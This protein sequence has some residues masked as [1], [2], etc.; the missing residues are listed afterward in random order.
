[1]WQVEPPITS[2][3]QYVEPTLWY[4]RPPIMQPISPPVMS[5]HSSIVCYTLNSTASNIYA[6][7]IF[8]ISLRAICI[9]NFHNCSSTIKCQ[10]FGTLHYV[11]HIFEILLTFHVISTT[12]RY[13]MLLAYHKYQIQT[14]HKIPHLHI[15][16]IHYPVS[17]YS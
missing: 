9:R 17:K 1:M 2:S 7:H 11:Q 14:L 13:Q 5:G 8:R 15:N 4:I 10:L 6:Q 3:L 16:P 12:H